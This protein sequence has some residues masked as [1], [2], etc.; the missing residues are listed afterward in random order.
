MPR[1][2]RLLSL[3]L[4]TIWFPVT[5]HCNLE[6]VG[7]LPLQCSNDCAPGQLGSN[8]GC[9]VVETGLAKVG[10]DVVKV[11]AP[12][13]LACA[14][15]IFLHV[16]QSL[17]DTGSTDLLTGTFERPLNWVTTWHFVRRAAPPS[18]APTLTYA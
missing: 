2:L 7:L 14:C 18:R 11:P 12:E 8:D 16:T 6:A 15:L 3:V 4:L 17:A 5:Q 13:L 10:T 1:L 9:D